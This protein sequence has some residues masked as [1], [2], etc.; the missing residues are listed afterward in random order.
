VISNLLRTGVI[1]GL[2][3]L[4]GCQKKEAVTAAAEKSVQ[5]PKPVTVET[6]K[7]AERSRHFVVVNRELELGGT[8]YAY[9]DVDGDVLGFA[10]QL[11][12]TMKQLAATQPMLAPYAKDYGPVFKALGLDDIKALGMSSVAE[13]NGYF[14]NRVFFYTPGPR[15]GLLAGV[16]GASAPFARLDLA[17]ADTD[18]YA[19][20]EI[21]LPAVYAT[22][23]DVVAQV[24]GENSANQ[25]ELALKNAGHSAAI[26]VLSVIQGWKGHMAVVERFD[27]EKTMQLPVPGGVA[28]PAFSLLVSVDGL[29]PA[30][31]D[32]LAKSPVFA[33]RQ[34]G[35]R[36]IYD[37]K[38]PLPVES[39]KP[40]FVIDGSTLVFATSEAFFNECHQPKK[41]LAQQ[42]EFQQAL[43]QVGKEGNG[44]VYISPHFFARLHQLDAMN[45]HL[46]AQIKRSVQM[47]L[48]KMPVA[49]HPL[50]TVRT[51]LPDGILFRSHWNR[52]LKQD[53]AVVALYNPVTI[54]AM[55]AMAIPAFQKVRTASQEKAV[56][57]NLRQLAAAA[58]QYYLEKGV[59]TATYQEL[60][61]PGKYVRVIRPVAGEDYQKIVFKQGESLE[62]LLGD[63]KV[64]KYP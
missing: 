36:Q 42:P 1:L 26:S 14:R 54:G 51:N 18:F 62:V 64:I 56:L 28:L 12:D 23:R 63:G 20:S 13:G 6:V 19:E 29:A 35:D 57:N 41:G 27:G 21:D 33:M 3:A 16:G 45:P 31:K 52:S 61:G 11:Q 55:A 10:A 44:L 48:N 34:V 38:Q 39:L 17:P 4:A 40:I 47:V 58:D 46:P 5:P 8:L 2:L 49:D 25:F 24:G 53:V 30:V 37:L 60:V 15:H 59:D 22:I 7:E 43:A 32:A 9:A 50:V